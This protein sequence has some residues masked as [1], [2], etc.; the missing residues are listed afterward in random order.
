MLQSEQ[1]SVTSE[2]VSVCDNEMFIRERLAYYAVILFVVWD[3]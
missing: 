1:L 2:G 3:S